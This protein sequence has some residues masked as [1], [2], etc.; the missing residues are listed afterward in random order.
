MTGVLSLVLYFINNTE[1]PANKFGGLESVSPGSI[2]GSNRLVQQGAGH[3]CKFKNIW[4]GWKTGEFLWAENT[5]NLCKLGPP[6]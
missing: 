2:I 4:D 5:I 3:H 6:S 1:A